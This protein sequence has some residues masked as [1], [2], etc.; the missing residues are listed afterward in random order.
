MR[1]VIRS[2]VQFIETYEKPNSFFFVP[3]DI[4][5]VSYKKMLGVV[6]GRRRDDMGKHSD[7][8]FPILEKFKKVFYNNSQRKLS[9]TG[10]AT[11]ANIMAASMLWYM[12]PVLELPR[13]ILNKFDRSLFHFIW[14]SEHEPIKRNTLIGK[15]E[16]GG[17]GMLSIEFMIMHVVNLYLSHKEEYVPKW[18]HF[19]I[20]WIGIGL[21]RRCR[22]LHLIC[23]FIRCIAVL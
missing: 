5:W 17:I 2:R 1:S 18:V 4:S 23:A 9:L 14:G 20:Y 8:W 3:F 11:V 15:V 10:K 12:A 13:E 21:K 22:I 7:N 6:F 16:D 19:A